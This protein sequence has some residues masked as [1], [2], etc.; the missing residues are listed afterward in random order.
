MPILILT[1]GIPGAGKSTWANSYA[2]TH[3]GTRVISTDEIRLQLTGTYECD[4]SLYPFIY[5]EAKRRASVLL[6]QG[7]DVIIDATN[8]DVSEWV[9]YRLICES[10]T[11][12]VAKVFNID[13]EI[14]IK[15]QEERGRCIPRDVVYMKWEQ[16]NRNKDLIPHLFDYTL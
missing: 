1:I 4:R 13:P 14:A 10:Q 8:V 2:D 15:R 16:L 9:R 5:N 12:L 3:V 7:H 11:S 6:Q